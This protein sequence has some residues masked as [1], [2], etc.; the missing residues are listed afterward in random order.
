MNLL[1]AVPTVWL[2]ASI[3]GAGH[4]FGPPCATD[5]RSFR[6]SESV[7]EAV[8]DVRWVVT[9]RDAGSMMATEAGAGMRSFVTTL[10]EA[11][12]GERARHAAALLGRAGDSPAEG[13]ASL[14]RREIRIA[15]RENGGWVAFARLEGAEQRE[16]LSRWK[17]TVTGDGPLV[18]RATGVA[19]A[20][21]DGWLVL[22]S[23]RESL[24]ADLGEAWRRTEP[25]GPDTEPAPVAKIEAMAKRADGGDPIRALGECVGERFSMRVRFREGDR[26]PLPGPVPGF[27]GPSI[28]LEEADL[29]TLAEGAILCE[30]ASMRTRAGADDGR[31]LAALPEIRMPATFRQNLG[32]RRVVAIGEVEGGSLARPL[33]MRCP[34]VAV[35]LEVEDPAQACGEQDSLVLA[36]MAGLRRLLE[37][38][39]ETAGLLPP[40][41]EGVPAGRRV[42]L[43]EPVERMAGRNP[44]FSAMEL[45]W[46]VV[47]G[48]DSDWQVY[49]THPRWCEAFSRRLSEVAACSGSPRE[50]V[51]T[52][53]SI[54]RFDGERLGRHLEGW[55]VE[56]DRF[57]GVAGSFW[58]E[59][60]TFARLARHVRQLNWKASRRGPAILVELEARLAEP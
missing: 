22:A 49:A 13:F 34:A 25:V 3:A 38:D 7:L 59:I 47:D 36:A 57:D 28:A 46:G 14:A 19:M 26:P 10:A 30:V 17:P 9:I 37:S 23:E 58:D 12:T 44:W 16:L 55:L 40:V 52:F 54:G 33:S 32:A 43:R 29:G 35:A 1:A 41:G 8:A 15:V 31:V 51:P 6:A 20:S 4:G 56:R 42:C 45:A 24:P 5:R 48:S 18:D 50:G 21:H 60:K 27:E 2:A 53:V 11:G 39:P